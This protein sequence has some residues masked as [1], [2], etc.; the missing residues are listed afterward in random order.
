MHQQSIKPDPKRDAAAALLAEGARAWAR[1]TLK[2]PHGAF[3]IGTVFYAVPSRSNPGRRYLANGVACQCA[4]YLHRS[5]MC[6]HVRAVR[7]H[8]SAL[9]AGAA[10]RAKE[11]AARRSYASVMGFCVAM[12]C[13]E[14]AARGSDYCTAHELCDAF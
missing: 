13:Q 14:D 2:R 6:A 11:S 7:L 4:D 5:S 8:E 1:L 10:P 12:N 3:P 9:T